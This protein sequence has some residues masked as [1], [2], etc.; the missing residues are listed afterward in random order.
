MEVSVKK[1]VYTGTVLCILFQSIWLLSHG[2]FLSF[3]S[4][5]F[6]FFFKNHIQVSLFSS[7]LTCTL[8]I[9]PF[10]IIL[11]LV[12]GSVA[13]NVHVEPDKMRPLSFDF[14]YPI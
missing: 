7:H 5:F 8:D 4:T 3:F 9:I 11:V 14:T 13:L 1:M 2:T 12:T 10:L 6:L